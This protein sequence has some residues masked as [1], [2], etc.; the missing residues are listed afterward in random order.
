ML[1]VILQTV[2]PK[3]RC[4]KLECS[5][6]L[7]VSGSTKVVAVAS[8]EL[9][10]APRDQGVIVVAGLLRRLPSRTWKSRC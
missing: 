3:R 8:Q 2:T 9:S 10:M 4:I 7:S 1:F 6:G 5:Q